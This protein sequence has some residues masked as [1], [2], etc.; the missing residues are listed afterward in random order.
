M[1]EL[2]SLIQLLIL[3]CPNLISI[4]D[5]W[6][7]HSLNHLRIIRCQKLS[8]LP[9]GLDCLTRLKHLE[10][11][12]FCEELDGSTILCSIQDLQTSLK[13]IELYGCDKLKT[14]RDKILRFTD[15][16]HLG[17]YGCPSSSY[18]V[19][20]VYLA[21]A[22]LSSKFTYTLF[23]ILFYSLLNN[24]TSDLNQP[25]LRLYSISFPQICLMC[26]AVAILSC[27]IYYV[28]LEE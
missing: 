5:L 20:F 9:D 21:D 11:G 27:H 7:L 25:N 13:N 2:H 3:N 15:L 18:L 1:R 28:Q 4:G 6:G 24:L 16:K 26:R 23:Y 12:G 14:P 17:I 22:E 10:I 19:V 8:H